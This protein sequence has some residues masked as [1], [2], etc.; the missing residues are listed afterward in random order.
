MQNAQREHS[1]ILTTFIRLPF[2]FKIFVL[3]IFEWP[4]K[5]GFTVVKVL[6]DCYA[7]VICN[8]GPQPLGRVACF[9]FRIVPIVRGKCRGFD[10]PRQTWR[11]NVKH[12]Y[13]GELSMALPDGCPRSVGD[14]AENC[15]Q[16]VPAVPRGWGGW[17]Q[18]T[19]AII[20]SCM[21]YQRWT[22]QFL[23]IFPSILSSICTS[24]N[25]A[26][27]LSYMNHLFCLMP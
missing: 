11:C 3:Y 21:G 18:M 24:C 23:N 22:E 19:S 2:V 6:P 25:Y 20:L 15:R 8:Y 4:L 13:G 10:T 9:Y 7:S 27:Y 16:K 1:A 17:L 14:I 5:T 12:H 26:Y